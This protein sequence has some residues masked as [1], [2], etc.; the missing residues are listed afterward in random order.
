MKTLINEM[1][2]QVLKDF[3]ASLDGLD[4]FCELRE[5]TFTSDHSPDYSSR[6]QQQ[7]YMLRYFPAYLAEYYFIYG[8]LLDAGFLPL[9]LRVLSIGCG[10]GVDYYGLHLAARDRGIMPAASMQYHGLDRVAWNYQ[11]TLKNPAVCYC[12]INPGKGY[13]RH[14]GWNVYS[15]PKS[16][17]E[18]AWRDLR[19]IEFDIITRPSAPPRMCLVSSLGRNGAGEDDRLRDVVDAMTRAQG[20]TVVGDS[21]GV[22]RPGFRHLRNIAN[23]FHVPDEVREILTNL[24]DRCPRRQ[25]GCPDSSSRCDLLNWKPMEWSK[26]ISYQIV[27]LEKES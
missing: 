24:R 17:G 7:L 23:G 9:P 1:M 13:I 4:R 18:L 16:I 3:R 27:Y 20:Y 2:R 5:V 25:S 10:C 8:E 22:K 12:T 6:I 11:T 14:R 15:F 26:Y 19:G 21:S